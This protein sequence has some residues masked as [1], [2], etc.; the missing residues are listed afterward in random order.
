[1]HDRIPQHPQNR[2]TTLCI[3]LLVFRQN[4]QSTQRSHIVCWLD[5]CDADLGKMRRN[6]NRRIGGKTMRYRVKRSCEIAN[7]RSSLM[8]SSSPVEKSRLQL[9]FPGPDEHDSPS[10]LECNELMKIFFCASRPPVGNVIV[11]TGCIL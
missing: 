1:M 7:L 8:S 11:D 4:L 10:A 6:K 3:M 5:Q 2:L 9:Y